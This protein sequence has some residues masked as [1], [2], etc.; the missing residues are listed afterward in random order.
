MSQSKVHRRVSIRYVLP[1]LSVFALAPLAMAPRGCTYGWVDGDCPLGNHCGD[2]GSSGSAG[3][4]GGTAATCGGLLG[5]QCS[6]T[7]EYCDFP[8]TAQCGSADQTGVCQTKPQ[9]CSDLFAPVCGCDG[10]TYSN[11]CFAASAGVSVEHTGACTDGGGKS[12]GGL[13]GAACDRG[14]YCNFPES[15]RC[16]SGD[17]TGTCTAIPDVCPDIVQPVCGCDDKTYDN[18]CDAARAGV[19][20]RANGACSD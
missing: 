7:H 4:G 1:L 15:T 17:Q 6:G 19:S 14:Q 5:L 13:T 3:T 12:C 10:H 18:A 11:Q 16:G 20:V 8:I 2:P 9:A